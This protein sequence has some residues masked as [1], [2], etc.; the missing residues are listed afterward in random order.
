M[1]RITDRPPPSVA[2]ATSLGSRLFKVGWVVL[3]QG[4]FALSNFVINI[5]FARWLNPIDYGWFAMSFSGCLLLMT[6]HWGAILEPLLVQSAQVPRSRQKGFVR[7][8]VIGHLALLTIAVAVSVVGYIASYACGSANIGWLIAGSVMGGTSLLTLTTG[9][10]VCAVFVSPNA[11]AFVGIAYLVGTIGTGTLLH[12]T[13]PVSWIDIWLIIGGWSLTG[14]AATFWIS[15]RGP[16]GEEPYPLREILAF[17]RRF[18][19]LGLVAS[20]C[21]WLRN[22]GL[23]LILA[24]FAGLQAVAETRAVLSLGAPL[25]QVN[26]AAHVSAV[27]AFSAKPERGSK[28]NIWKLIS[29]YGLAA[30]VIFPVLYLYSGSVVKLVYGGR[31]TQAAWQL[32]WYCVG[33]CFVTLDSIISSVFKAY[34]AILTSYMSLYVT[35]IASMAFG[36]I[37]IPLQQTLIFANVITCAIALVVAVT[38]RMRFHK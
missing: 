22:D 21:G 1:P 7:S 35:G 3:D 14:A 13:G 37:L 19:H 38:L 27:V 33:L 23:Y 2:T 4:V 31:Y 10:R 12:A 32:P 9:R 20:V 34:N 26:M 29:L 16:S 8:L 28:Q 24:R 5:L 17:A 6:L 18:A 30:M 25:L 36:F 11:S 15:H